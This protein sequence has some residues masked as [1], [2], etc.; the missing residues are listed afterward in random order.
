MVMA[1]VVRIAFMTGA[2]FMLGMAS[3]ADGLCAVVTVV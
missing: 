2:V 3:V 1:L